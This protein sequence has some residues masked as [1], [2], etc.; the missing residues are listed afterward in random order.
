VERDAT[1]MCRLLVGLPDVD[2]IGIVRWSA[3]MQVHIRS[4][5]PRP[6]CPRCGAPAVVKETR[7]RRLVDLPA[8]GQPT[9]LVWRQ[10]RWR[11]PD[12]DCVVGSWTE[13]DP[14]IVVGNRGITDRAG[15]WA[16]EQVG[17]HGRSVSEVADDLCCDSQT[18]NRS[19]RAVR[20][21]HGPGAV[22]AEGP[23]CGD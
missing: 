6:A 18:A 11:C 8:F 15:R 1:S 21:R 9:V 4:T 19:G 23:G 16:C 20:L 12:R 14:R 2:V 7:S 3:P 5:A 22:G 17:R 13:L 10:R